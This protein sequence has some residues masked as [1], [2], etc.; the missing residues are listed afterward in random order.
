MHSMTRLVRKSALISFVFFTALGLVT[1]DP[2]A[3]GIDS[4]ALLAIS[5]IILMSVI[6]TAV[7]QYTLR[8]TEKRIL[9]NRYGFWW[10][11]KLDLILAVIFLVAGYL[12]FSYRAQFYRGEEDFG[13][14]V[15][16][17]TILIGVPLGILSASTIPSIFFYKFCD[18]KKV[19]RTIS[20]L[21]LVISFA[22]GV[23]YTLNASSCDF[24]K[25]YICLAQRAVAKQND[26]LCERTKDVSKDFNERT[27]CYLELSKSGKWSNISLCDKLSSDQ[28]RYHCMVNIA[29]T[30]NNPQ[31]CEAIQNNTQYFNKE[32]C[33]TDLKWQL[34]HSF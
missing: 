12:I 14:V 21:F 22:L 17:I 30:T 1:L 11:A 33:Y 7:F 4:S 15:L 29:I 5:F 16:F 34:I 2:L 20:I 19:F 6:I 26:S 23:Y 3:Y 27:Y 10:L 18:N 28:E 8:Q 31:I 13:A 25:N 9:E 24:N 32:Q